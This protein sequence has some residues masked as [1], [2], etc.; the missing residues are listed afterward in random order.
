M[1]NK[2]K[3]HNNEYEIIFVSN[4]DDNL[5]MSDGEYHSGVTDF[6]N[7]KIYIADNLN[8]YSYCYTL[9]HELTHAIID[10]Y[11]LLQV[12]WNDEIVAD[13]IGNYYITICNLLDNIVNDYK[14]ENKKE[15]FEKFIKKEN[16]QC[17]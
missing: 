13:F 3:I 10:S 16:E 2:I 4:K 7:K 14:K 11:G 12:D 5:L 15:T 8:K 6:R 9:L 1:N 17:K